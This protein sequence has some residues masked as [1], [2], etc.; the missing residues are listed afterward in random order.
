MRYIKIEGGTNLC[1]TGF[2]EFLKTEM[3]D[4]ELDSYCI[5]AAQENAESYE[6]HVFGWLESAES[7]AQDN[8]ISIEEAETELENY[9]AEA[10][11][12]WEE[13]TE[14]EYNENI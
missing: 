7:Y 1:G 5:D 9:Y 6:W 3:T 11:A 14:E 10:Y 2:T 4:K 13:I 12:D 8:G